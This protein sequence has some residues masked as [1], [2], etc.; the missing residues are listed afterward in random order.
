MINRGKIFIVGIEA[1]LE[2]ASLLAL[3]R[4]PETDVWYTG[5]ER[6]AETERQDF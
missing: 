4:N 2:E 5:G 3:K 6:K 1:A